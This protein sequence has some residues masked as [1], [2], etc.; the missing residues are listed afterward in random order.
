[1]ML[2]DVCRVHRLS[3][4]GV[5]GRPAG[6]RVLADRARLGRQTDSCN[7]F[8]PAVKRLRDYD[9]A[10]KNVT[11]SISRPSTKAAVTSIIDNSIEFN[12]P[13]YTVYRSF[14][15][16]GALSSDVHLSFSNGGPAT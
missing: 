9:A 4:G 13:L 12:V 6:W 2:S 5:C 7:V 16:L 8:F 14:R 15:R 11:R 10:S 1:M 3:A